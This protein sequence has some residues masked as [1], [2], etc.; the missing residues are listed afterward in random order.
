MIYRGY[1]I[2]IKRHSN[3]EIW[4]VWH[5]AELMTDGEAAP[6]EGISEAQQA[7]DYA[8]SYPAPAHYGRY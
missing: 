8:K 7:I 5:G 1:E 2:K 4:E 3:R 6:G